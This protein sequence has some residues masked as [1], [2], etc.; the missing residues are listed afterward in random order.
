M[1]KHGTAPSA[2]PYAGP[3]QIKNPSFNSAI[4]VSRVK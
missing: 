2:Q 1:Q 4:S 3:E